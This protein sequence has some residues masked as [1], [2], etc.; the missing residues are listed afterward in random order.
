MGG[1]AKRF[2]EA[3]DEIESAAEE[4]GLSKRQ[5]AAEAG[6]SP[7]TLGRWRKK[8]PVT[9][10]AVEKMQIAIAKRRQA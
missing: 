7:A 6:C 8:P 9:V 3:L 5:L 10:R 2:S 1:F 4:V